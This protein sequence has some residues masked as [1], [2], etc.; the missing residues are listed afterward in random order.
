LLLAGC[1][2]DS[3][4]SLAPGEPADFAV[5]GRWDD[6]R[7]LTWRVDAERAPIAPEAFER[8]VERAV[9]VWNATG[10]V[11]LRPARH[12]EPA[13]VTLSFRR[14]HHGACEPFGPSSD[15]A[16]AGPVAAGTFVHFDAARAWRDDGG[17]DGAGS[18][19]HTALHELGHVLGLGHAEAE[20]AVM[21]NA[22]TRPAVLSAHDLAGLCSLYGGGADAPGD[23]RVLDANDRE[24]A[25][26]RG[27]APPATCSFA[28][29]DADGDGADDVLVWRT[30]RE[31]HGAL[32]VFAFAR[33]VRLARTVGPFSGTVAPGGDVA[34]AVGSGGERWLV[35]T[36]ANGVRHVR[37]LDRYGVPT[38]PAAPVPDAVLAAARRATS[39]DLD[40]DGAMERV[41]RRAR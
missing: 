24:L 19:F 12:G 13:T 38:A 22:V 21:S 36:F 6:P 8:A 41:E 2:R 16:H 37:E 7:A 4:A 39:G 1:A 35:V 28:V 40:G 31:G 11:A 15:V 30:D 26:L 32:R 29:A 9:A 3:V 34:F 20:Q 27:V 5:R 33:G 23:L 25:V 14:G 18:V 10:V 17:G